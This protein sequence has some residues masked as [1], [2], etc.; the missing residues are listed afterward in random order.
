MPLRYK[1]PAYVGNAL[2]IVLGVM[3][4][5]SGQFVTGVLLA[6][7]ACLNVFLVYK[8]DRFSREE[9]WLAHE[10]QMTKLREELLLE[11]KRVSELENLQSAQAPSSP[12]AFS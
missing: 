3:I 12:S 6:G 8:L 4:I 5:A 7:L 2:L 11:R 9:V 1:I 10:I